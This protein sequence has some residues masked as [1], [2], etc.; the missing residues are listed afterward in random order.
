[1]TVLDGFLGTVLLFLTGRI[2]FNRT[3]NGKTLTMPDGAQ[4]TIFRRVEI[5]TGQPEPAAWFWVRFK[6]VRMGVKANIVFS[7]LPMMVFMGF[8]GFHSK[9]WGV[10][11]DTG[12]C[13]GLY[14]WQ[15]AVDAR[16]YSESVAMRFMSQR[17]VPGSVQWGI[18]NKKQEPFDFQLN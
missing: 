2:K 16:A 8:K 4:F 17:S 13:Q 5:Q 12:L 3:L 6:P 9:Y 18:V 15:T 1:M 10:Q 14:E 7:L 11:R